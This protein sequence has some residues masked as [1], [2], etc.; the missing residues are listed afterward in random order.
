[1]EMLLL[2]FGIIMNLGILYEE[3]REYIWDLPPVEAEHEFV[4]Q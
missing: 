2:A 4:Y 1:M 3:N